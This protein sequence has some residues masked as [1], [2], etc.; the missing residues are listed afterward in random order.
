MFTVLDVLL[1]FFDQYGTSNAVKLAEFAHVAGI[2]L[3]KELKNKER[4]K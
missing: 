4:A 2:I 1:L 3:K